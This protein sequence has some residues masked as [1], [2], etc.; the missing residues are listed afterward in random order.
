MEPNNA[1]SE[2]GWGLL[3]LRS[4]AGGVDLSRLIDEKGKARFGDEGRGGR[5]LALVGEWR[6]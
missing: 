1:A 4:G 3:E 5:E 2:R 6:D